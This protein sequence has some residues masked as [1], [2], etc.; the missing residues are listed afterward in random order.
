M[1]PSRLIIEERERERGVVNNLL[2]DV[3]V[4]MVLLQVHL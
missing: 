1:L 4:F 2:G 3:E